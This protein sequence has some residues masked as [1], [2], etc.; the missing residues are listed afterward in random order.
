MTKTAVTVLLALISI[1]QFAHAAG[2]EKGV[3]WSGRFSGVANSATASVKGAEA[4]YFNPAG[5]EPHKGAKQFSFNISPTD[6]QFGGPATQAN[7]GTNSDTAI[8]PVFSA[9]YSQPINEDWAFGFGAFNSAG[10]SINY[11]DLSFPGY[12]TTPSLRSQLA[13]TEI[14]AGLAYKVDETFRIGAAWRFAYTTGSFAEATQELVVS[15]LTA[16]E[17]DNLVAYNYDGFRFGMQWEPTEHLGF[18]LNYRSEL[19][20]SAHGPSSG[21]MEYQPTGART[22]IVGDTAQVSTV[23]PMQIS[24][25]SYYDID[26]G[27]WRLYLEY[28]WTQYS[29]NQNIGVSSTLQY[30]QAVI[31]GSNVLVPVSAPNIEQRWMDESDV[32]VAAEYV[33][34]K[35]PIR[36]GY[37]FAS[38]VS[39]S[40]FARVI[41]SPPGPTHTIT[42]GT[43]RPLTNNWRLDGGLEYTFS[44]GE[45]DSAMQPDTYAG[46][47]YATVYALHLGTSYFF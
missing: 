47:Y 3:M 21:K 30:N 13:V 1:S 42:L 2:Y 12:H 9:L 33:G 27:V 10:T 6:T 14:S 44:V 34:S 18:G 7:V 36:V 5:L 16:V 26:P 41:Y 31:G 23:L 28:V 25:G 17:I 40:G 8:S 32:R 38:Q 19:D 29:R 39:D 20:I 4:L 35:W 22:N 45:V 46:D 11:D 37:I 24:L 15:T 43:G